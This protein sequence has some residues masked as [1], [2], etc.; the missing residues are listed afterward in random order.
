M[1]SKKIDCI[2]LSN[3]KYEVRFCYILIVTFV[4][5]FKLALAV[6]PHDYYIQFNMIGK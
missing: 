4:T 3:V 1:F 6:S 2:L 5:L